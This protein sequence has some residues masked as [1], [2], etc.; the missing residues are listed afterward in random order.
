MNSLFQRISEDSSNKAVKSDVF[1]C[2]GELD[3]W[4]ASKQT[5]EIREVNSLFR[6]NS[7]IREIVLK[8]EE[9]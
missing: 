5:S 4:Q 8:Q 2:R 7:K 3:K 6:W 9:K 1:H